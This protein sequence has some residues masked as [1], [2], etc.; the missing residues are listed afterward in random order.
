MFFNAKNREQIRQ[1]ELQI[2]QLEVKQRQEYEEL[3]QRHQSELQQI[4]AENEKQHDQVE[5][6]HIMLQGGEMLGK[7]REDLAT[8]AQSLTAEKINLE[9]LG[10]LFGDTKQAVANLQT[11]AS[12]I[13]QDASASAQITSQLDHSASTISRLISSI[14]E[15]SNQTN[16]LALNAAIEAARAGEAGRGFAVVADEVRQLANKAHQASDQIEQTIRLIIDQTAQIRHMVQQSQ[17]S[18]L[19]VASSSEQIDAVVNKVIVSSAH[20]QDVIDASATMAFLNTVKLDHAVWKHQIYSHLQSG[21]FNEHVNAHTECR[22]GKWYFEGEGK[23]RYSQHRAFQMM[24]APHKIVHQ[25]GRM[26]L[27]HAASGDKSSLLQALQQMETASQ[28]VTQAISE[29]KQQVQR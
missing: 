27:K 25:A 1:L 5:V 21:R 10:D 19:D 15:I 14:Q 11:R 28:Q 23:A 6:C 26:A 20:M 16:L 3:K 13:T 8:N 7:I 4:L 22:L 9:T 24:D 12:Q 18:A 17:Q 29:L 2:Q